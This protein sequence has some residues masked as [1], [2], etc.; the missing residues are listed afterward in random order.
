MVCRYSLS[1]YGRGRHIAVLQ[2]VVIR[3][4]G[5]LSVEVG[6]TRLSLAALENESADLMTRS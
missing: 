4:C 6:K 5:L 3:L 1:G 2:D